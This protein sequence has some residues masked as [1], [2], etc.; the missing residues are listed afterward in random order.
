[1]RF[2]RPSVSHYSKTLPAL[3]LLLFSSACIVTPAAFIIQD[4]ATPSLTPTATQVW[5]PPTFT[6]SPL[7]QPNFTPTPDLRPDIGEVLLEDNFTDADPWTTSSG[8]Q[9]T[10][11]ID[12]G[13]IHL[14]LNDDHEVL[15]AMRNAPVLD[16]FYAE[17]TASP[18]LCRGEDEYGF[19]LRAG[20]HGL[21]RFALTCDGRAKVDRLLGKSSLTRQAGWLVNPVVPSV[22]PASVRLAVWAHGSQV[23]LFVNDVYLFSVNDTVLWKGTVGVFVHT[24]GDDDVSVNFSDLKV[25]ALT[26]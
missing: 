12:D 1:L 5:F 22:I 4:T 7:P 10:I 14:S 15:L 18:S 13:E 3:A 17:I 26:Q 16:N 20:D 24:S 8:T 21:Y 19:V 9:T 23:H 2:V 11:N 6:P 25:W